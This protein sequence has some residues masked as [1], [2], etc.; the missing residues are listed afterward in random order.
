MTPL[1]IR[2]RVWEGRA[3]DAV[4]HFLHTLYMEP[5]VVPA[6]MMERSRWEALKD[7][8]ETL[9]WELQNL[10]WAQVQVLVVWWEPSVRDDLRGALDRANALIGE[11]ADEAKRLS[12]ERDRLLARIDSMREPCPNHRTVLLAPDEACA[13]CAN[14]T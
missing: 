9:Q 5:F 4:E 12:D 1:R 13:V 10:W 7:A 14:S 11:A 2:V 3:A 8:H 6:E